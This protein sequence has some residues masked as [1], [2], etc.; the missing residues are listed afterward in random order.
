MT[1]EYC[2]LTDSVCIEARGA[3]AGAFLHG[4]LSRSIAALGASQAPLAAWLDAKGRVRALVRVHRFPDRWVLVTRGDGADALLRKLRMFVLRAAV[5]LDLATDLAVGALVDAD[6]S[7]LE[8]L[9]LPRDAIANQTVSHDGARWTL[10]GQDYWQ[11]LG[12]A[13]EL[14]RL[15]GSLPP[16]ERAAASLAAIRAGIPEIAP[17]LSERY[18]AQMLNLDALG[19]LS[20]DKGCYPGQEIVARVHNLGGVKRRAR[21]YASAAPP[22]APGTPVSAGDAA[23]G[24][25]LS[26][27]PTASGCELLALVDNAAA[28]SALASG[29]APLEERPLPFSV[30]RG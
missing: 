8:R 28:G 29:G 30:P 22:L 4:Q 3:D 24:E 19:A 26:S 1:T 23:V 2:A 12:P 16:G 10:V 27:A 7:T 6:A 13:T 9:A 5:T 15:T 21:R 11:V 25:V 18:V 14:A 20:L 17:A